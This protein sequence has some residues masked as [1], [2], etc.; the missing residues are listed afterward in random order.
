MGG[1]GLRIQSGSRA[2]GG[3]LTH[4]GDW[5]NPILAITRQKT[6]DSTLE[7]GH[8][9]SQA[10]SIDA[11]ACCLGIKRQI[12]GTKTKGERVNQ[13]DSEESGFEEQDYIYTQS[14]P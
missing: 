4:T 14:V 11:R 13:K 6:E 7:K 1:E 8:K 12:R 3:T 10:Q 9:R 2:S 5:S